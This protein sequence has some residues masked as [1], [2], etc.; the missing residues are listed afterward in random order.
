MIEK[1]EQAS[2]DTRP[3]GQ[4]AERGRRPWHAPQFMLTDIALTRIT[5]SSS[6][7]AATNQ[8]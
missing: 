4:P 1:P 7:D 6:S 2:C 8:S 3:D 5:T